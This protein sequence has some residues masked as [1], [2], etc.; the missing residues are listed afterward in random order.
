M[1]DYQYNIQCLSSLYILS[2]LSFISKIYCVH[3]KDDGC[4]I[5]ARIKKMPL[6]VANGVNY[7][8]LIN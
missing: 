5:I 7:I 3:S 1:F 8:T 2:E 6:K 4:K